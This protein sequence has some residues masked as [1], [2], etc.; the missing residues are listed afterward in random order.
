MKAWKYRP[1]TYDV[2]LVKCH[3]DNS[4]IN[5]LASAVA[6]AV[7][8]AGAGAGAVAGAVA[9]AGGAAL[10]GL[11][12]AWGVA[13]AGLAGS[14]FLLHAPRVRITAGMTTQNDCVFIEKCKL[15]SPLPA[16]KHNGRWGENNT[17]GTRL[18]RLRCRFPPFLARV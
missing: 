6:G 11:A 5:T 1:N 8:G 15:A 10:S 16:G 12:T 2:N 18:D 9:G 3:D 14:S 13:A 7:A 4:A 17:R